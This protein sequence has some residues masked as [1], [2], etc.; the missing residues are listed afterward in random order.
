VLVSENEQVLAAVN[1]L[2]YW[3][4]CSGDTLHLLRSWITDE[5]W[6]QGYVPEMQARLRASA[7]LVATRLHEADIPFVGGEAGFFV[8]V[9][10]RARMAG[11]T[12]EAEEALWRRLL[13]A[14]INLTPG[15]AIRS[16][17]PGW[18]RLCFASVPREVLA[19][20]LERLVRIA[21]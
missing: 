6:L 9:D 2:S 4:C 12:W 11:A 10:L 13:A 21:G 20:A 18:F 16:A 17:E 5:A 3:A 15:S 19:V 14:G 8:L 1:A 7:E